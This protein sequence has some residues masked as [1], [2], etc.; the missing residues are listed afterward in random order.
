MNET[1]HNDL[2]DF[3]E[4]VDLKIKLDEIISNIRKELIVDYELNDVEILFVVSKIK[5][6]LLNGDLRVCPANDMKVIGVSK[7]RPNY[8]ARTAV[9]E[10][11]YISLVKQDI[12]VI[13]FDSIQRTEK[14]VPTPEQQ[15]VI[16]GL[17]DKINE[18]KFNVS[19]LMGVT[20]S[21]KT[22]V[23]LQAIEECLK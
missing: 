16:N 21:G 5:E 13:D 15:V 14:L 1:E 6:R 20:G 7:T 17:I 3:L 22:E 8:E 2:M 11:G 18:N 19:L 12:N 4:V 9:E 10:K 23:Y